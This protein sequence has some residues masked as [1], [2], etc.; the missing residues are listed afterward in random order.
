[1]TNFKLEYIQITGAETA[2]A[3]SGSYNEIKNCNIYALHN[4]STATGVYVEGAHNTVSNS[5]ISGAQSR[6]ILTLGNDTTLESLNITQVGTGIAATSDD[7]TITNCVIYDLYDTS[8]ATGI[9][10]TGARNTISSC[11]ISGIASYG[12]VTEGDDTD[13]D[14]LDIFDVGIGIVAHSANNTITNCSI[15]NLHL[16][17][18]IRGSVGIFLSDQS[19]N[20]VVSNCDIYEAEQYG[21]LIEGDNS[22]LYDLEVSYVGIGVVVHGDYNTVDRCTIHDLRMIEGASRGADGIYLTGAS[23]TVSHCDIYQAHEYG[24]LAEGNYNT[25]YDLEIYDVGIGIVL[26]GDH[27]DRH[28]ATDAGPQVATAFKAVHFRQHDVQQNRVGPRGPGQIQR[29]GAG[30]GRDRLHPV[31]L[32]EFALEIVHLV[33]VLDHHDDWPVTHSISPRLFCLVA[34][35]RIRLPWWLQ[36]RRPH[37]GTPDT[38]SAQPVQDY[39]I[40]IS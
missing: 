37:S 29:L 25:L 4:S 36:C 31:N 33:V 15:Y 5:S 16:I 1:M 3:L 38:L 22:E 18:G 14:D 24:V 27:N 30:I 19:Y 11:D 26:G 39:T 6:G 13:L 2:I 20:N 28:A 32:Q 17:E 10:M 35:G 21:V 12:I 9:Y 40:E 23:N 34:N 7:N 8:N